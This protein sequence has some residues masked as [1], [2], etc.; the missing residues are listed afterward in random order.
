MIATWHSSPVVGA[1]E[2]EARWDG[3]VGARGVHGN[4]PL[5]ETLGLQ[6]EAV[7]VGHHPQVLAERQQFPMPQQELGP[8][9]ASDRGMV[10]REG[11]P[12]QHATGGQ[13]VQQGGPQRA[14]QVVGD[15]HR[16]KA[17]VGQGPGAV[18]DVGLDRTTQW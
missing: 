8:A 6:R 17:L 9:R 5:D 14:P 4:H 18:F 16:V 11:F 7:L 3:V 12:Q 15:H 13:A 1:V 2:P 10:D